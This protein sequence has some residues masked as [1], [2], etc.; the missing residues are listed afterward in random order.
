MAR[1]ERVY[2][3]ALFGVTGC[4]KSSV[5]N[6]LADKQ[7]ANVS[8]GVEACTRRAQWYPISLGEKKFRLWDTMGFNQAEAKDTNTL[9]PFEQAHA[10]L[11][12]LQDGVDL[13]LL[14]A[15]KDGINASLRSLYWLLDSFF[16]GGRAQIALVLTHF[17]IPDDQWWGRN[18]NVIAQ[19]CNIPV[20]FLPYVCITTV[21]NGSPGS[22]PLYNQSKQALK[23][24]L[25]EHATAPTPLRLDLSSDIAS[26]AAA[27]TLNVHCQLNIPDATTLVEKFRS[28]KRPFHAILFGE[29]GVGKSSVINLVLGDSVAE[30]SSG[31]NSCTLGYRSYKINTGLH[32]FLVWDTVGLN[33]MVEHNVCGRAIENAIELIRDL[34]KQGGVDLLVFCKKH[35][36]FSASEL[37][38]FR[39]FQEFLC[40]GQIPVA[41]I[42]T[43]LEFHDPMEG[44]W[45]TNGEGLL[46]ACKLKTGAVAG[47]AC[48]TSRALEDP[49]DRKHHDKLSL[50]R[51]SVQAMLEDSIS[52]GS[53]FT[54]DEGIWVMS[55]LKKLVGLVR[56]QR[57]PP[58]KEKITVRSLVERCGLT[59]EQAEELI[60]LLYNTGGP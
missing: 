10:L 7:V 45:E 35:G 41:F 18:R 49:D 28:P 42:I 21:Q 53:A 2:K 4:G 58:R 37:S 48:I 60:K 38:N 8:T 1:P 23:A 15:R 14:C 16:F 56:V 36:R 33:D 46:K 34:H 31:I 57:H 3:V 43:H 32:Q 47:H 59:K 54:K 40:E 6:L 5:I 13:V 52:Y 11:R 25:Q 51:Q 44:W 24:L 9:S 30:V 27:E 26:T 20:Q 19:K 39:L 29:S 12:N 17:D 22:D 55:F 50:S